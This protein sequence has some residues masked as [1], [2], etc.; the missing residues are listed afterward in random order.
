VDKMKVV[1]TVL[2]NLIVF[3][4]ALLLLARSTNMP[5][6][7]YERVRAFTR[8]L[9][10]DYVNWTLD[11]LV[12]KNVQEAVRAPSYMTVAEQH[13][14]VYDYMDVLSRLNQAND[15]ISQI[16]ADPKVTNKQEASAALSQQAAALR[17]MENQMRPLAESVIQ[18]QVGTVLADFGL[19]LAGQPIPPVLYHITPL[20]NALI[21]SP[22]NVIRQ[23]EDI[24]LLPEMT[25]EQMDQ[26]EQHVEKNLDVSALVV[27]IG[28]VG[29][30]PTMV[31]STTD[32]SWL[33]ETVSHEW[34]HNFLT[35]RPLGI[36]YMSSGDMRTINETTANI[37]GKEIGRAV[38]ERYYPELVPPPAPTQ[39]AKPNQ[40][41]PTPTPENP[42]VFNFNREMH[43]TRVQ[44]DELLAAGKIAE[45]EQYME[46]RRQ[47][48]VQHGYQIRKLNQAY[49]AFYGAYN[50]VPGGGAG[51]TD[52]VGPAVQELRK[53][54]KSLADFLNRISWV[55][56]FADLQKLIQ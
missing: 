43:T 17:G 53:R 18:Y 23:E 2:N 13:K 19:G 49:F 5:A 9:E 46:E 52:P 11:A 51:G 36:Q 22:R 29:T 45:A 21:I 37:S 26:L 44:T 35:L 27:P 20:P 34:T 48:F 32:L 24:S 4:L 41:A 54:S 56:S 16:Y 47:F 30:Y 1:R 12:V 14:L 38:L 3:L 8:M 42:N 33:I 25:T 39:E 40:P 28:G 31:M 15:K 10:F 7:N 55:S 50:D 6:D